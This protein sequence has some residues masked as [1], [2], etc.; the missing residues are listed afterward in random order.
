V[1][2]AARVASEGIALAVNDSCCRGRLVTQGSGKEARDRVQYDRK[3][4][5]HRRLST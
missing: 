2:S 4:P 3:R 1:E 5:V